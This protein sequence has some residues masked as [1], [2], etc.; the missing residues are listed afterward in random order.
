[1][2]LGR[3][4]GIPVGLHSSWFVIFILV[5]WSLAAAYFPPKYPDLPPVAYWLLGAVTSILFF[6]SVFLHEMG[7]SIV[8]QRNG[9]PVSSIT[10][11]IFGGVAQIARE[12]DRPGTEFRIAIAGPVTSLVLFVL[13]AG[14][15]A[16][17]RH[18]SPY[19]AAPSEW[20][21]RINFA[22]AAFNLIPGF[23]LD[24]GR[25]LRALV[26]ARTGSF[27]RAT[28]VAT[29]SGQLVAYGFMGVGLLRIFG[30]ALFD[31]LWLIFIGWFLQ[32]AAAS[33]YAQ[34]TM[35][36]TLG[37]VRVGQVMARDCTQVPGYLPLRRV[38]EDR[39][40]TG[41][42]RCFFVTDQERLLGMLTLR[43]IAQ[44]PRDDWDRVPAR[45]V[46]V[47]WERLLTIGVDAPL[48][49]ALKRMDD[50][51]VAQVPVTDADGRLIGSLS[52]EQVL[53]YVRTR[54]ELG[55]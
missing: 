18:V 22:L 8:A 31:G 20:L 40:L 12:P 44:V 29:I 52:R 27:H 15:Y 37:G 36:N 11:F 43:D 42:Q 6:L 3:I 10:L 39:V 34:V 9:I 16:L 47:P 53:H 21:A 2:R 46:M 19:L 17:D 49:D 33:S 26:W 38:V 48:L 13:F 30:G 28:R 7:H 35:Q 14:L 1:V 45:Q 24:G 23:P 41:G 51:D 50:A 25:V 55:I 32:N 5:T 54:A 4:R